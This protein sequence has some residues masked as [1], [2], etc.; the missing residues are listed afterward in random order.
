MR[1]KAADDE[2]LQGGDDAARQELVTLRGAAACADREA[3]LLGTRPV[4]AERP[5]PPR[6]LE[7]P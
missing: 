1:W 7:R 4:A 6:R 3:F 5:E 2:V